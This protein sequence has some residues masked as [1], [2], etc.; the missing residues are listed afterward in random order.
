MGRGRAVDKTLNACWA[1]LGTM[2][3]ALPA[4]ILGLMATLAGMPAAADA[5]PSGQSEAS[6]PAPRLAT[7]MARAG[8]DPTALEAYMAQSRFA[9]ARWGVAALSLDTG[10]M[11]YSH[12][13]DRLMQTASTAKLFTAAT[14]LDQPGPDYRIAT[15]LLGGRIDAAGRLQGPLVLQGMGDPTLGVAPVTQAWARQLASQLAAHGVRRVQGDLIADDTYFSGPPY[16]AGWEA[17]DL[18]TWFGATPSALSVNENVAELSV[19][20]ANRIGRPAGLVLTP[21]KAIPRIDSHLDTGAPRA[22]NAVNLFRAPGSTT[23]EAFGRI[24]LRSPAQHYKLSLPDPARTAGLLLADALRAQGIALDGRVEARH[25][26]ETPLAG[27]LLGQV[28]SPPLAEILQQGLKRS[29][30]LYLQ[31]LLQIA[32]NQ[33]AAAHPASDADSFV[34]SAESGARAV[35]ALLQRAGIDTATVQFSDG[36]GMSRRSLASP[37]AMTGLLAWVVTQ[38]WAADFREGLPVAAEDGTLAAH[39]HNSPAAGNLQAKTGSMSLVHCLAGYVTSTQGEHL[40][41]VVMLNNYVPPAGAPS[42]SHDVDQVALMLTRD[43]AP[44]PSSRR[45]ARSAGAAD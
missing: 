12:D 24:A 18:Q 14:V 1:I 7:V 36:T 11:L 15:R 20:P 38:P 33:Y 30:N 29:Q 22:G 39:F 23:L 28:S 3:P 44:D 40:A 42:I 35:Q 31:N 4:L 26:P 45:A 9:H 10:R 25:W 34:S 21:E 5:P 41:F 16:G 17:E 37:R 13:A 43:G 2:S 8:F 32:G 19:E 27:G 6:L